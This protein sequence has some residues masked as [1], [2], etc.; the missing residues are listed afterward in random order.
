[1][2][3]F[4]F[5]VGCCIVISV[6]LSARCEAKVIDVLAIEYPPFTTSQVASN[7]IAFE[8]L[9]KAALSNTVEW[10]AVYAPPGRAAEMIKAGEWCASFYPVEADIESHSIT[11][12]Q[13]EVSI[14]LVR[15]T[16]STPFIWN[17]LSELKGKSVA[18]LRTREG[19]TFAQQF[20]DAGLDVVFIENIETGLKLVKRSRVDFTLSDNI[21]YVQQ[22]DRDLQFSKTTILTTPI[23]LFI[24]P[25]CGVMDEFDVD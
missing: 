3:L 5:I 20:S 11:L 22:N 1:M 24:N 21:S 25:E 15:Q 10:H 12:S 14:G 17:D 19:S 8:L 9:A 13:S 2:R 18:L 23:T 16:Q 4:R 7:G 6:M